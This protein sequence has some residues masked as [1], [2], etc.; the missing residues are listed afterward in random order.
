MTK[1]LE[2]KRASFILLMVCFITYIIIGLTRNAYSAAIVGI[3]S[4]GYFTKSQ[5][6]IISTSFSITYC[7]SQIVGSYFVDRV[8]P[9]KTILLG[10]IV[11]VIANIVMSISPTYWVIFIARG[12]C[13]IAQFGIWPAILR[14]LSEYANEHHRHTWR[15]I[16]PMGIT[17]GSVISYI[18]AALI[19][20][21]RGLFTL[22]YI[23]M[24]IATVF[25]IITIKY[26]NK[27]AV[28]RDTES[29]TP[30]KTE[31]EKTET[32][33]NAT[34]EIS[35]FK[36]LVKSGA[37]FFVLPVFI[38]SLINGGIGSWMPTMLM[39]CYDVS[40]AI[41]SA[42]TTISTIANYV[43]VFWVVVLYPRVFKL[44][45]TAMGMLFLFTVPFLLGSSFIGGIPMIVVVILLTVTNTF[46]NSLHQFN[47]VEVPGAFTKYNKAGMVAGLINA[48]AT[49][50]GILSGWLWGFMAEN[51]SWNT[52][53]L[54]WA[55]MAFV[56]AVCCFAATPLW[57]KFVTKD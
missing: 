13:G 55:T 48:V 24:A 25:F 3:I 57:K 10:T 23:T 7:I 56:A 2:D 43:A 52:I 17:S 19:T 4:E 14:I 45:S 29:N 20:N 30:C 37:V 6:G 33:K 21:W 54:V 40:P 53:V 49:G 50:A 44:Q 36:L 9:F 34:E 32:D 39:E 5:A 1:Y 28:I 16:L 11:T 8:S 38:R 35:I 26:V 41:S 42:M 51:C 47:T 31:V 22:S 12:V 46:K 18:A 15:Y 27:K